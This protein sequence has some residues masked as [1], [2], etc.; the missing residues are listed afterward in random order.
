MS[1]IIVTGAAG[2]LGSRLLDELN[3][4]GHDTRGVD[5]EDGDLA[6]VGGVNRALAS[7][8]EFPDTIVHCAGQPGRVFC[9]EQP[10]L[11][12]RDNVQATALMA[13]LCARYDIRL[14]YVSTSEV[15][16]LDDTTLRTHGSEPNHW[17]DAPRNIYCLT[18]RWCEEIANYYGHT[19]VIR[20]LMTYGPG[21]PVG[22][23]RAAL[24]TFLW[25]ALH[26]E[27]IQ[28]HRGAYRSWCYVDDLIRGMADVVE[29]GNGVYN[30]GR[31]D[32]QVSMER[33]A[34]MACALAGLTLDEAEALIKVVNP[35]AIASPRKNVDCSR[36]Y[37]MG[38]KPRINLEE[39]MELTLAD[40][41]KTQ[42]EAR[43]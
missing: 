37:E 14:V 30:V 7:M 32:E 43:Q 41:T 29:R 28:V 25:N 6:T 4:R 35:P 20:P 16:G 12:V 39:G 27:P 40:L 8:D 5:R 18:K 11:S 17:E 24:P 36:L 23:G 26:N 34:N 1:R 22:Y 3:R 13:Q 42:G 38:W 10:E 2:Y 15:Y 19:T 33:I 31:D 21:Q 9:E